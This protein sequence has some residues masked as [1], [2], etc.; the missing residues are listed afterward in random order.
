M[1][2][3]KQKTRQ[4]IHSIGIA[5]TAAD[6]VAVII[7][8]DQDESTRNKGYNLQDN[9]SAE[10]QLS[11]KGFGASHLPCYCPYHTSGL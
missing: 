9:S 10:S 4:E 7:T 8:D 5:T 1:L 2:I 3:F 6:A 11:V